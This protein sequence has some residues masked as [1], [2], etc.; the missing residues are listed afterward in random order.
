ML[1]IENTT[2]A[3]KEYGLL[4]GYHHY[5]IT[6][7]EIKALLNGKQLAFD[8]GEYSAFISMEEPK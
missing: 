4:W 8:N 2:A 3:Q 5:T 6:E 1:I 7:E